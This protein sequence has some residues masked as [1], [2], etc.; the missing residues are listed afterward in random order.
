VARPKITHIAILGWGFGP[1]RQRGRRTLRDFFHGE[2]S[3][4]EVDEAVSHNCFRSKEAAMKN[5]KGNSLVVMLALALGIAC[6]QS[7]PAQT[8]KKVKVQLNTPLVQVASGGASVWALASN[9]NP[10][11]FKGK[12]FVLANT[13]SLSQIA[14]G[15]GNAAQADTVWGLNSS[16]S[17]YRASKSGT[18]WTFSQ[19]PG[20]LDDIQVGP[21]YQGSCHPYEVWGLN[22]GSEIFRYNFCT[23]SFD[24]EPGFLCDIH[25]GGGD[26]WGAQCGPNVFRFNFSTG[27][28]DQINSPFAAFPALTVGPN[29][30]W[31]LSNSIPYVFDLFF[32]TFTPIAGGPLTQIQAGGNGVWGI[33]SQFIFRLENG[34]FEWIGSTPGLV[35]I[36]V[37]SGGGVWG[38]DSFG[39]AYAFST[40]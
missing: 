17:I 26:I 31:A 19:V 23:N 37:G 40:P 9:G 2:R 21:G 30:V 5:Q 18:S 32:N 36:S 22:T 13:I 11:V 35:S 6:M 34:S 20:S 12:S 4:V 14:V 15:G 3:L 25:V 38:L 39:K 1:R 24:Q 29:G 33:R 10:C 27:V 8:F 16:G 28:F 7:A